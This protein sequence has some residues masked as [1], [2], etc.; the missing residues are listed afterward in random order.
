M[1]LPVCLPRWIVL[2]AK[3]SCNNSSSVTSRS[4]KKNRPLL[5]GAHSSEPPAHAIRDFWFYSRFLCYPILGIN[6]SP[7]SHAFDHLLGDLTRNAWLRSPHR[8]N[9]VVRSMRALRPP[10]ARTP[11]PAEPV[12]K[13]RLTSSVKESLRPV[14][15]CFLPSLFPFPFLQRE[16]EGA[17]PA[18]GL[19][20]QLKFRA[21]TSGFGTS[22]LPPCA[23]TI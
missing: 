7:R 14:T 11:A 6:R 8:Q 9:P 3:L 20:P 18:P 16:R 1:N 17:S 2:R 12:R 23:L 13:H 5:E 10:H 21:K 19:Q 4:S 15:E 22:T